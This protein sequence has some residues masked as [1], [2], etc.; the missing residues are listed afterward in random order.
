METLESGLDCSSG[1]IGKELPEQRERYLQVKEDEKLIKQPVLEQD[2]M[3]SMQYLIR[4]SA[5]EDYAI[6]VSWWESVKG[7]L[8]NT[9]SI[10]GAVKWIDQQGRRIKLV[11]DEEIKWVSMDRIINVKS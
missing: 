7:D 11:N 9:C 8:G 3:E 6:T 5:R 10:W 4:D 1:S 2:E